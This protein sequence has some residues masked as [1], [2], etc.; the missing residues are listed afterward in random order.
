[1]SA[2]PS[3]SPFGSHLRARRIRGAER[4]RRVRAE[5]ADDQDG[6]VSMRQ[7]RDIGLTYEEVRAEVR[8]GRWH[9]VGLRTVSVMGDRPVNE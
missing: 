6:V 1:M 3:A 2:E 9:K 7:L 8:A 5:L 4:R